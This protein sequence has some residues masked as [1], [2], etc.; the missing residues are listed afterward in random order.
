MTIIKRLSAR[1]KFGYENATASAGTEISFTHAITHDYENMQ[2]Y[3][4]RMVMKM[5][6][7]DP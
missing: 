4:I 5:P 2:I 1:T 3:H 6:R 7:M